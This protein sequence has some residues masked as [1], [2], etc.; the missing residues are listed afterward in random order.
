MG[1][2]FDEENI[3]R[4]MGERGCLA[5]MVAPNH[6][7]LLREQSIGAGLQMNKRGR[8]LFGSGDSGE[9]EDGSIQNVAPRGFRAGGGRSGERD[10]P[11]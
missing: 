6:P 2:G 7:R 5:T 4:E 9:R 8:G 1:H 11:Y 3:S 10:T